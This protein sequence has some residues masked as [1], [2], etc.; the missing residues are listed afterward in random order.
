[1]RRQAAHF[2]FQFCFEGR[3]LDVKSIGE[4]KNLRKENIDKLI[5]G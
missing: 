1:M 2:F 4:K 3:C 5:M